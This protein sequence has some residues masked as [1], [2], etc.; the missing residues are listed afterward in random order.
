LYLYA[1]MR[2]ELLD[3]ELLAAILK[4]A[5]LVT[6][7]VPESEKFDVFD[8]YCERHQIQ[9]RTRFFGDYQYH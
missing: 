4:E 1:L 5:D 6:R 8:A 9:V 7:D 2:S 3:L